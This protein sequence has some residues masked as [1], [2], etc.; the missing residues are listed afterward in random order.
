MHNRNGQA[1][2]LPIIIPKGY[3]KEERTDTAGIALF[4][5]H[6][7]DGAYIY[8]AYLA[9]TT[10]ELQAF[11]KTYHQPLVHRLGGW[12][13]KGQTADKLFYREI[14]QGAYRFGYRNVSLAN[15]GYFDSATNYASLQRR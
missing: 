2:A 11:D 9:D 4:T 14:R 13:Y 1:T 6:Y 12:V 5:F 15:E 7:P 8:A 10:Y 3:V